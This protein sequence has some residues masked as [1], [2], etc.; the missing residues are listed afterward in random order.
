[1]DGQDKP[2][3]QTLRLFR[4]LLELQDPEKR[5]GIK[6]LELDKPIENWE[7]RA[8]S[9][10]KKL[11]DLRSGLRTLLARS[12]SDTRSPE[13][14]LV[15]AIEEEADRRLAEQGEGDST[16]RAKRPPR[17]TASSLTKK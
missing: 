12:S 3:K 2:S 5:H 16:N 11:A 1:M 7:Y 15:D 6:P 13:E 9:A 14:K 4:M 17:P 8:R 10:E